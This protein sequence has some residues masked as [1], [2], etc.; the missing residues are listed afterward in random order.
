MTK[1]KTKTVRVKQ[2][3]SGAGRPLVH[4]IILKSMGLGKMNRIVELPDT[5]ETWGMIHKVTHL[6]EVQE[7]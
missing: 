1:E 3:R 2:V 6:V 5:P 7:K 4:K